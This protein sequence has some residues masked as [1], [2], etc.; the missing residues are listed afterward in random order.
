MAVDPLT[1][2]KAP[3]PPRPDRAR[4]PQLA[5]P[6]APAA[7]R[8]QVAMA[9]LNQPTAP[10]KPTPRFRRARTTTPRGSAAPSR[11]A[12]KFD[13]GTPGVAYAAPSDAEASARPQRARVK[14]PTAPK[15][16]T[17]S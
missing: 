16:P 6:K 14:A 2:P 7:P 4:R 15:R 8:P 13:M 9:D 12:P 11:P 1:K 10:E 17:T 5:R 3:E